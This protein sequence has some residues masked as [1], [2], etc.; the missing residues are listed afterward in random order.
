M[1]E[2]VVSRVSGILIERFNYHGS[3]NFNLDQQMENLRDPVTDRALTEEE[4]EEVER[5]VLTAIQYRRS[6]DGAI[7][8]P[9]SVVADP[10][11]HEEWYDNWLAENNNETGGYY[12]KR[13]EH[14][15]STVL[16]DKYGPESAGIIVRSI[17]EATYGI[18]KKLA[19]PH[20][21]E[22]SYKG[23]VVGY[24]QSGKTA[25]FSALIAKAAD[26]GYKLI[27]VLS[28]IHSIL[29]RQTQIRLDKELTGMNDR[30]IEEIFIDEPSD[31]KRWNRL[32]SARLETDGEFSPINLDPF[33]S[34][35]RRSTPT[36]AIIKKNCRVMDRLIEYIS[37]ADEN[38][39][40]QMPLLIIDDEADQ[41]SID[42]NANEPDTEPSRTNEKI[43]SILRLFQKKAYIGYTAT[44]FASVLIDMTTEHDHL[45]DDLYPR[46]FIV[47]LPE[48]GGYFGTSTIFEG[49]LSDCFV[50]EIPDE[51]ETLVLDSQMTENL[52][53]AIDEFIICCA[54]RNIRGDR[55][56]PMSMLVH[57]SHKITDMGTVRDLV[58]DYFRT[59]QARDMDLDGRERLRTEYSQIWEEFRTNADT[60]NHELGSNNVLPAFEGIWSEIN[61]VLNVIRIVALN[62]ASEDVL[63]Y[64]TG[65][66][67][68]VIAIGGNQLSRGLTL[69]GLMT[70]YYLR[71]SRQYDTLLQ[72]ARW[73]GY[74]MGYEDLTRVH[75]TAELWE[76]FEHLA[77]VEEEMRS[78][79]YRYE[80][81]GRTP[82][83][84]AIA[85]R[86]HRTLNITAPNKIGAAMERQI[87]FS[88]SLNQTIWFSL[89]RPEILK[90]N[91][92]LGDSFVRSVNSEFGFERIDSL[93]L[94]RN[95]P[96]E[97]ILRE[98]LNK[99][100]FAD[101]EA[102]GG[103]GLD[104]EHLLAYIF[105]RLN[106]QNPELQ[107]WSIAL[108]SNAGPTAEDDPVIYGGLPI[109]RIQRSRKH[110]E[111]GYNIGVLTDKGHLL[112]DLRNGAT[113]PYDGRSPQN[114]LLL[115]YLIWKNSTAR[116]PREKPL[117]DQRIN[118]YR[119][120]DSER[121]DVLGL[122]V[123][124]PKSEYEPNNYIG[125]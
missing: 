9:I 65:E 29:R 20:R 99:Y 87:S 22:F 117:Y 107:N 119:F 79:I 92:N 103:P 27:V 110:T 30:G 67:I 95:I 45:E 36:L 91:Y 37:Q 54:V 38:S 105:R 109:N 28:G 75:T 71:K 120:V 43:R 13:L 111:R 3:E 11:E 2:K 52:A 104:S 118:L 96:G 125:Q 16:T 102:T 106:D 73:F 15:L 70:S 80:E 33:S 113:S 51:R 84:M 10:R 6:H 89:N 123:V 64:T 35:C 58:E 4:K 23:L 94:A 61:N 8:V 21:P 26:A 68:K 83:E 50:R 72:M 66:E 46:N 59:L 41:A 18:I 97:L 76:C 47:S 78:E 112:V 17:D 90:A 114:P 14:Y 122:A 19:N 40:A 57:V 81:E 42:I 24:V 32:S 34:F 55:E 85:I 82:A 31:A 74:R 69:E 49:N 124:L 121:I 77:L 44:P 53:R 48:P 115:F 12:W 98:F 93:F 5:R 62:S 63:D 108:V 86:A 60:I 39:R 101:K 116:S 7:L 56:K 88:E 100:T 25:N 1:D